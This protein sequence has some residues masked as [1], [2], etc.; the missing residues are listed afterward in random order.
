MSDAPAPPIPQR[1]VSTIRRDL[2]S[3]YAASLARIASWIFISAILFRS[4]P[5]EFAMFALIRSTVGLLNYTALGMS[6]AVVRMIAQECA[7]RARE[8][9]QAQARPVEPIA[10]PEVQV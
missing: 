9:D 1:P 3:A 2:F 8:F 5:L 6:P 4:N 10:S 7:R